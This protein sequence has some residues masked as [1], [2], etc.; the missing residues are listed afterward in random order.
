VKKFLTKIMVNALAPVNAYPVPATDPKDVRSLLR[1]LRPMN[2]DKQ[3]FR[4]GPKGDGGYL[5]PDDLAGIGACFSPGVDQ[6]AGFEKACADLGMKVFMADKSVDQ[7]PEANEKFFF[8]KKYI[9]C[10]TNDDFMTMDDWV[11]ASVPE[12]QSDL[13]LQ[14]DIEG[15]EYETFLCMS[16][17]LLRRFR[18]IVAEVHLLDLLWSRH[19][20]RLA[21]GAFGKILQSHTCVHIHPNNCDAPITKGGLEIPPV[22]EF[23]FLR[24]D[25]VVNPV[26]ARVFPNPLDGDNTPKTHFALPDCWHEG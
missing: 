3:L 10:T 12:S 8:T 19:F 24:N 23:T 9:G 15:Y 17:A 20:F 14:I 11:A 4:M 5:V 22:M 2:T 16:E 25:R 1:K 6:I 26:P 21:S 18:V 13:L 7:A